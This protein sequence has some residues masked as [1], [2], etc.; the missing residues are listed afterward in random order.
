MDLIRAFTEVAFSR[1][2]SRWLSNR[3]TLADF[4]RE[5]VLPLDINTFIDEARMHHP[6]LSDNSLALIYRLGQDEWCKFG[7]EAKCSDETN[8]FQ[9]LA[10]INEQIL[11]ERDGN[12]IV[13]F[14]DIFR[15]REIT[16]LLGEDL[17][18]CAFL[19]FRDRSL[20]NN[21]NRIFTW[22]S[23]IH[24]D[25]PDLNYLFKRYGLCE[26]H[27]HLKASSNTF[28]I[29]WVSLMNHIGGLQK[30]FEYIAEE[31]EPSVK[32]ELGNN[33]YDF[34]IEAARLRWTIYQFLNSKE[35]D[36]DFDRL[37]ETPNS[38]SVDAKTEAERI[39]LSNEW[40]PDYIVADHDSPMSVYAGERLF[41]YQVLLKIFKNNDGALT[42]ALYKYVLT[43]SLLRSYFIQINN[44]VGFSNF[45]RFQ[46]VKKTLLYKEYDSLLES[47]PL[48]EAKNQNYTK[49]F[50]TRIAPLKGKKTFLRQIRLI[51]KFDVNKEM[52]GG[53]DIQDILKK[54]DWLVIFHF[55]KRREKSS[56]THIRNY[57]ARKGAKNY[58]IGLSSLC[59][60]KPEIGIDAASSEFEARPEVF[61]QAF[62]FLKNYG[63]NATFHAG[64]DFYDIAD[65]L[66]AI[67]E[68]INFLNLQASDRIGHAL[69]LGIDA[70]EYYMDRHNVAAVPK[71]WML[72]N[73]VWLYMKSK[74]LGICADTKTEWFLE[75]IYKR[76]VNEIGYRMEYEEIPDILDYWESMALRGDNPEYYSSGD[77]REPSFSDADSWEFYSLLQNERLHR[78]RK[79]NKN[80]RQLYVDYHYDPD[81]KSK[82]T[83][84]RVFELPALYHEFITRMQDA[85]IKDIC[86]RHI[87]IECCPSSNVRIGRLKRFDS[88][89]IV[90]F[91]PIDASLSRYPLAVTVNTDDLGVFS[92]SLPNEFSLLALAMLKKTKAD[93]THMYSKQEVYDWIERLIENGHKYSFLQD[94]DT[95]A[96]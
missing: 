45:Q 28:E 50:E 80:A 78:I 19:A 16:Q 53:I 21:K 68:A 83:L 8:I 7:F 82:G 95:L 6:E 18:T 26:L 67:D 81:I 44:N 85:M 17:M 34:T 32:K 65:G 73:V 71:Q 42:F 51:N 69:A 37:N 4:S 25:N 29:T 59:E 87:C 36:F 52:I 14:K 64:E 35:T 20:I 56:G 57:Q 38:F 88:H 61:A 92:T 15:W 9:S 46:N 77:I 13:H 76:L 55:L 94:E 75:D 91:M 41:L 11:D 10:F 22:P 3:Q 27:S 93:G 43:K 90:R 84:V 86:R 31:H 2:A 47:L 40:L 72:D 74:E 70:K 1:V 12:P 48:W 63:F 30:P 23:V 49:I 62:R 24:N 60:L 54:H 89:P 5:S 39:S 66:R 33:I 79:F 58:G 96:L